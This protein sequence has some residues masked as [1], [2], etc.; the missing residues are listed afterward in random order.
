MILEVPTQIESIPSMVKF[1]GEDLIIGVDLCIESAPQLL[2]TFTFIV[3][4]MAPG[5]TVTL[6]T[7][8]VEEPLIIQPD[9]KVQ[10]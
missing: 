10:P 9:G 1:E 5:E 3:P 2:K 7:L 8:S 4:E 6:I